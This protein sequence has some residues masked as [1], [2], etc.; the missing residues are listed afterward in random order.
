MDKEYLYFIIDSVVAIVA[1]AGFIVSF[2]FSWRSNQAL[3]TQMNLQQ[4]PFFK[5]GSNLND[6][7]QKSLT[8]K[9]IGSGP[10]IEVYHLFCTTSENT[11]VMSYLKEAI[12]TVLGSFGIGESE[13]ITYEGEDKMSSITLQY[14]TE[15]MSKT[16]I[17]SGAIIYSDIFGNSYV[18]EY[19][20]VLR[21]QNVMLTILPS[22]RALTKKEH[23]DISCLVSGKFQLIN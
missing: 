7:T 15:K 1:V 12:I 6:E 11:S 18:V 9:N 19:N 23:E 4:L 2:Y 5:I 3:K 22:P 8:I 10:A 17:G 16:M 20:M 13:T 14:I 21:N